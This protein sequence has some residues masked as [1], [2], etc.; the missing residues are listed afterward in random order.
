MRL[1]L[2]GESFELTAELVRHQLH[3]H[4]PEAIH[5]YAVVIDG[6]RWPVK[7]VIAIA[8]GASRTRFQSQSAQRWLRALG[9]T[10]SGPSGSSSGRSSSPGRA[11]TSFDASNLES[12]EAVD[13][14]I[15]FSWL[16]AGT[17]TLDAAGFPRFPPLPR[18]PGL[19]R[20]DFGVGPSGVRTLYIG[21]SSE[22]ARRASNYRNAKTDRTR[23]RTSRRIHKEV[24]AHLKAGGSIEFAIAIA[25]RSAA[26]EALDLRFKS[27]RRLAENAAV[28]LAQMQ[29]LTRVLNIDAE[30]EHDEASGR[31]GSTESA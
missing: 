25:V 21:E 26:D 14:H 3:G 30:L 2:D 7:Q 31:S 22:L 11:R 1:T 4:T 27:A 13:V 18:Q 23:Q 28:V 24:V 19:Y 6:T 17:L 10:I 15:A 16:H 20:F 8:T 9:F 29:P 5:A 12:I